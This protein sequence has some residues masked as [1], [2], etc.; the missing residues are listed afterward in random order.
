M[1]QLPNTSPAKHR[2]AARSP[3]A[4]AARMLL[5][6]SILDALQRLLDRQDWSEVTMADVANA[7]G[8]SRQTLYNEFQSRTGL[9]EAYALRLADQLADAV[10]DAIQANVG[11]FHLSLVQGFQMF[12]AQIGSDPLIVSFLSGEAKPD[13]MRLLTTDSGPII[14]RAAA[15][16]T[17]SLVA[18]WVAPSLNDAGIF[19]RA[20][21]RL[22][23]SYVSAPPEPGHDVPEE[24]ALLLQPFVESA[25]ARARL[26]EGPL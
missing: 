11:D 2:P 25:R 8:V 18:S 26:D 21:V 9:V 17:D 22:A 1:T 3:Y 5:R 19:A 16:L 13:L 20:L 24:M 15:R 7:A 4:E 12:F 10:D 14:Q 23:L 6:E